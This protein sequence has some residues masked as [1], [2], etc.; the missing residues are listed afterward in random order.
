MVLTKEV[1]HKT[2]IRVPDQDTFEWNLIN[3]QAF[4]FFKNSNLHHKEI[5]LKAIIISIFLVYDSFNSDL[6]DITIYKCVKILDNL[7]EPFIQALITFL[8]GCITSRLVNDTGTFIPSSV[9]MEATPPLECT[10]GL[11]TFNTTLQTLWTPHQEPV[12]DLTT[13]STSPDIIL[14]YSNT[15][16]KISS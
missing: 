15:F 13:P 16:S 2:Y 10:W 1:F 12:P 11:K 6:D 5:I 14:T 3:T 4:P 8:R 7:N 9:F